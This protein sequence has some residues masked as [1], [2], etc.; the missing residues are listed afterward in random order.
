[1]KKLAKYL[2]CFICLFSVALFIQPSLSWA[3]S[4]GHTDPEEEPEEEPP[5]DK[6]SADCPSGDT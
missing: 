3:D 5:C 6:P 4:P 1:M 2:T